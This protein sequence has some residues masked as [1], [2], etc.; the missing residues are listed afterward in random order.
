M[1][2]ING[3][4]IHS[5]PVINDG[6]IK[7]HIDKNCGIVPDFIAKNGKEYYFPFIKEKSDKA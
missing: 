2:D 6:K 5:E 1:F 3:N 7:I 4:F